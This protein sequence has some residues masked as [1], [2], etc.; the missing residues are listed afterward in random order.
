MYKKILNMVGKLIENE[1]KNEKDKEELKE[2]FVNGKNF[3]SEENLHE[4]LDCL[5][6]K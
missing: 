1:V 3:V 6:N 2:V 4:V 5:K